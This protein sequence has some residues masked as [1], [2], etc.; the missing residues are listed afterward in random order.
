MLRSIAVMG[1]L[2]AAVVVFTSF[3]TDEPPPPSASVDYRQITG[4][5]REVVDY[6]VL[7]PADVPKGWRSNGARL[8]RGETMAWHLGMLTDSDDYIGIEQ[9][10]E[11]V[12]S[13]VEQ[14]SQDTHPDG[15]TKLA[16]ERWKVRTGGEETTFVRR[17]GGIT[18]LVTGDAPRDQIESYITSLTAR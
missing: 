5:A 12:R 4:E 8:E 9:S 15:T 16:G 2:V 6:E 17:E 13:M 10:G 14:Y 11:S 3:L 1:V 18:T 7:A